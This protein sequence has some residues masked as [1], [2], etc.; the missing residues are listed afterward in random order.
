MSL[1]DLFQKKICICGHDIEQEHLD[2]GDCYALDFNGSIYSVCRCKKVIPM[3]LS[4]KVERVYSVPVKEY[5]NS[6]RTKRT[7]KSESASPKPFI[8]FGKNSRLKT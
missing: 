4:F 3:K 8:L 2:G 5:E 1:E 6:I 7:T